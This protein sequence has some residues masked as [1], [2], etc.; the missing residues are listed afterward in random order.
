MA[1]PQY[2]IDA[3]SVY[4]PLEDTAWDLE[5]V[6]KE[7]KEMDPE[8]HPV[9]EYLAGKTRFDIQAGP[10][11]DYLDMEKGPIMFHFRRLTIEEMEQSSLTTRTQG[12]QPAARNIFAKAVT[13]VD[14]LD[15][16]FPWGK[17][18]MDHLEKLRGLLGISLIYE[19][20]DAC[21]KA[22]LPVTPLERKA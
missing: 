20:G 4:V 21:M 16:D 9:H 14:N 17:L 15:G 7:A 12:P 2:R 18:T 5:R 1:I 22:S 19:V 13:K 10:V 8:V 11:L 6:N 3:P